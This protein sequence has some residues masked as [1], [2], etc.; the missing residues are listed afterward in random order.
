MAGQPERW[1]DVFSEG[2]RDISAAPN[3]G[4]VSAG[5]TTPFAQ[6]PLS[7]DS[8]QTSHM[9]PPEVG[10]PEFVPPS[11]PRQSAAAAAT[12]TTAQQHEEQKGDEGAAS[13]PKFW[14]VGFFQ[15]FFDV[16]T[17]LVLMRV[18]NALVPVKPPDFLI[19]RDWRSGGS[20]QPSSGFQEAEL[21]PSRKPDL[22][23]PFWIG[24]TLWMTLAIVSNIMSQIAFNK[25]KHEDGKKWRY[26]FTIASVAC[27]VIYFYCFGLGCI[28]WGLMKYHA[29]PISLVDTLCLYGYSLFVFFPVIFL[30]LIP[31][32]VLQWLF[33]LIGGV[34]SATYLFLN[35]L[36]LWM[37]GLSKAWFIGMLSVVCVFSILLTLSFK[38]YF[39]AYK[40]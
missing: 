14:N 38:F 6:P 40:V 13:T 37:R 12:A 16:D 34:W 4:G 21:V 29:L 28:M 36:P 8:M 33:V 32:S 22:Y 18:A 25:V 17:K 23:G 20:Q 27:A 3:G 19:N 10:L 30:S 9:R 39:L 26:D 7:Y 5:T 11:P 2:P 35:L 15:Q 31:V 24:T 1:D